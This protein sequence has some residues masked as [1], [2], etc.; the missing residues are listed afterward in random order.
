MRDANTEFPGTY[1][2]DALERGYYEKNIYEVL[3]HTT[4]TR[5]TTTKDGYFF[6]PFIRP[7][8][9]YNYQYFLFLNENYYWENSDFSD[10]LKDKIFNEGIRIYPYNSYTIKIKPD[11]FVSRAL[12]HMTPAF[13]KGLKQ[14]EGNYSIQTSVFYAIALT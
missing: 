13:F 4:T 12:K 6:M 5:V 3:N 1:L 2:S 9:S 7:K 10:Y 14:L 11:D 8:S